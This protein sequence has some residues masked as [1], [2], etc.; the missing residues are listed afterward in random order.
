[1]RL[2]VLG[3]LLLLGFPLGALG[4]AAILAGGVGILVHWDVD[5]DLGPLRYVIATPRF[6]RWHHASAAEARGKNLAGIFPVW[7][8]LFGTFHLPRRR[9]ERCGP[10]SDL[11]ATLRSHLLEPIAGCWRQFLCIR[12]GR[13]AQR[14]Q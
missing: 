9:A 4:G 12:A 7:D 6:H 8:L 14:R 2:G 1:M 5:V 11:P 3:F 10:S 13:L